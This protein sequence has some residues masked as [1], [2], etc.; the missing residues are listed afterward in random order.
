MS[1]MVYV[2]EFRYGTAHLTE[3]EIEKETDKTFFKKDKKS[4]G[5]KVLGDNSIYTERISKDSHKVFRTRYEAVDYLL[6]EVD[7]Y[8][9]DLG[10]NLKNAA[11]TEQRLKLFKESLSQ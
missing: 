10:L 7:K 9:V 4:Y 2:A 6:S 1:F 8:I 3:V 11:D 5:R